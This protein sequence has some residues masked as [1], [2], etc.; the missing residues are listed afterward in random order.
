[1]V[2]SC[3]EPITESPEFSPGDHERAPAGIAWLTDHSVATVPVCGKLGGSD[4]ALPPPAKKFRV[5]EAE[6]VPVFA[7]VKI[8]CQPPPEATCGITPPVLPTF[9][10]TGSDV[11]AAPLAR[12]P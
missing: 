7:S 12:R 4:S 8:V 11:S 5:A 1:L 3:A 10:S 2:V 6:V 9:A